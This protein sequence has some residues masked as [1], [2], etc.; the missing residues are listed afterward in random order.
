MEEKEKH[1]CLEETAL[2]R[3]LEGLSRDQLLTLCDEFGISFPGSVDGL[4]EVWLIAVLIADVQH[5]ELYGAI[6]RRGW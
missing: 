4:D 5:Q 2:Q 6:A 3:K 1:D